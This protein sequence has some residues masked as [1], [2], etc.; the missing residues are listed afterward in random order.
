MPNRKALLG[1]K[2][3]MTRLFGADGVAT[4]VTVLEVGPCYVTQ[5]KTVATDGYNAIQ[6]GFGAAK[7]LNR[8]ERGPLHDL[9]AVRFLREVRTDDVS[10]YQVGQVLDV[11]LFAEGEAVDISGV[12]KGKG[13]AGA[14]KRHGFRGG[15]MTHG[16]SDRQRAVGSIG[17]G[18]T[19][20]RVYK[21]LRGPSHM[22]HEKVT[23][24]NLKVVKV[25]VE[26]NLLL[27]RGAVP[28]A[29]KGLLFVRGSVKTQ[30]ARRKR[31]LQD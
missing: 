30:A 9:P 5:V 7:R 29:D 16:Q 17:S 22:G 18:T 28:G 8:P 31:A 4:P 19:P 21:G 25:D 24:L 1:R 10:K 15:P 27:V 23:V 3:G 13:F 11:S 12:S 6:I 26:R 2:I 14:M 20:G